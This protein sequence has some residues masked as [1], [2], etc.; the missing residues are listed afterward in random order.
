VFDVEGVRSF[1]SAPGRRFFLVE[2]LASF[3]RISS[4]RVWVRTRRGYRWR[5]FSELDPVR[6]VEVV[7]AM[8]V[9][10]RPG[11]YRR[12]GDV[13]LFLAGLFPDH[14]A[15]YP[16]SAFDQVRLL[17]SA[18]IDAAT[19]SLTAGE[20]AVHDFLAAAFYRRA[21]ETAVAQVGAAPSVLLDVADNV[22]YARR[23]LNYLAD[24][25]L[26]HHEWWLGRPA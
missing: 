11:G 6:L 19:P 23:I 14:T 17:R 4:G 2:L 16:L 3:T 1:L 12:L 15:R 13:L 5:R 20:L 25:Y 9:A 24:R 22:V 7:E 18:G 21:V 26:H 8:G 10:Q